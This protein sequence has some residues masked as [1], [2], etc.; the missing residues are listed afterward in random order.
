MAHKTPG[1]GNFALR[2]PKAQQIKAQPRCAEYYAKPPAAGARA[3]PHF[4]YVV[5]IEEGAELR[6]IKRPRRP[7]GK[8]LLAPRKPKGKSGRPFVGA[9]GGGPTPWAGCN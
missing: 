3:H 9:H 5:V 2:T 7:F 8:R 1:P 6:V 4:T